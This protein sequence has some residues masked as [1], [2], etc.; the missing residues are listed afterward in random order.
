M[1]A[2]PPR[3]A[4]DPNRLRATAAEYDA[5]QKHDLAAAI[6][7]VADEVERSLADAHPDPDASAT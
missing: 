3:I 7:R 5:L 2:R 6:R 4:A 1:D